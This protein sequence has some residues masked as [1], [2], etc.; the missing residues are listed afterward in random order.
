[1]IDT[2]LLLCRDVVENNVPAGLKR[3]CAIDYITSQYMT[4]TAD[5]LTTEQD[6]TS[7]KETRT[8]IVNQLRRM[9]LDV[10]QKVAQYTY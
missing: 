5:R 10:D 3:K 6:K 4:W 2:V 7:V 9:Q 1:M 8:T